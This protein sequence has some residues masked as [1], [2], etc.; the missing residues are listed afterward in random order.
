MTRARTSTISRR[1]AHRPTRAHI[2][3]SIGLV[4][5]RLAHRYRH[6]GLGRERRRGAADRAI[7]R[8]SRPAAAMRAISI[9][10]TPRRAIDA[11]MQT[12]GRDSGN[13]VP[14]PDRIL[15]QYRSG[16]HDPALGRGQWPLVRRPRRPAGARA[17]RGARHQRAARSRA[18]ACLPVALR[19]PDRRDEPQR[20]DRAAR[21]RA[22]RGGEVPR[23]L[24]LHAD[25]GRQSRAHQRGLRFRRR[26]RGDRLGR[27]AHPLAHARRRHARP[28]L[29][30]QVRRGAEDLHARRPHCG[31]GPLS[32]RGARGRGADRARPGRRHGHDRRRRGAAPC[33]HA[34][35]RSSRTRRSCS[36]PP[37]RSGAARSSPTGRTSS[38]RRRARKTCA[39][40]TR[41]SPR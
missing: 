3:A 13:G 37:R 23:L 35:T 6:A 8:A 19:R 32:R 5:L 30:Q 4:R 33:A 36:I 2:L 34:S 25:R 28:L 29:R 22:R 26:R 38:A 12:G 9:R 17:W 18:A 14:V 24:R 10:R 15:P 39:R 11:V 41:S 20:A 1:D 31:G 16:R 7:S 21:S 27:P 40:P